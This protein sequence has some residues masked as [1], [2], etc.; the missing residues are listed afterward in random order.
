MLVFVHSFVIFLRRL[1]SF[2]HLVTRS[3]DR[4]FVWSIGRLFDS[5]SVDRSFVVR[6]LRSFCRLFVCSVCRLFIRLFVSSVHRL[7][8]CLTYRILATPANYNEPKLIFIFCFLD[9]LHWWKSLLR[10]FLARLCSTSYQ[11]SRYQLL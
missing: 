6:S 11:N 1:G 7:F 8:V 10:A 4:S 3:I 5:P 2:V 9:R